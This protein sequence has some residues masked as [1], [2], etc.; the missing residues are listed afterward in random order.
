MFVCINCKQGLMDP[1]RDEEEL[2]YTDRYRCGHCGHT[3]TIASRLIVFTQILSA[4]LGGAITLYLL[5]NHLGSAMTAWQFSQNHPLLVNLG[6]AASAA[7][8]LAGFG[9]TLFR[10]VHNVYKRQRYLHPGRQA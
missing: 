8:L 10:A 5:L 2:D 6:L 9:Y 3:T 4:V 1:I 7:I